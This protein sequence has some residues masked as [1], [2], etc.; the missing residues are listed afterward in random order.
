MKKIA[1]NSKKIKKNDIFICIHDEMLDRHKFI[2]EASKKASVLV[3]DNQDNSLYKNI[4]VPIIKVNDTNETLFQVVNTYYNYPFYKLKLIGVT[5]TDGKTTT[6]NM[7]YQ[8]LNNFYKC[9]YLGTNGFYFEGYFESTANTTPDILTITRL[10][11]IA[12]DNKVSYLVMEV[13]SEALLHN[14]CN[15]LKFERAILTNIT[16]E[17]LN[18]HKT[19]DN[20]VSNKQKLFKMIACD[21]K[22]I[23][24]ADENY[25][26][27]FEKTNDLESIYYGKDSN[28][29]YSFSNIKLSS[30]NTLFTLSHNNNSYLINSNYLGLYN[31]YNLVAAIAT[32][33]SL[34]IDL[35]EVLD[36]IKYLKPTLGRMEALDFNQNFTIL[37]DYAHTTNATLNVFNFLTKVK[38]KRIISVVGCAGGRYKDKRKEIGKIVSDYSDIAIFTMDDPRNEK[39][40]NIFKDML[41]NVDKDNIFLYKNRKKAIN[42]ALKLAKKDDIVII[43]GKGRDSYMAI[44]N[45]HKKYSDIKVI[46]RF[47]HKKNRVI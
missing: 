16:K 10:A 21:G 46:E 4:Y 17:H 40:T 35:S 44:K 2:E 14:R 20:Y 47:F 28:C 8:L 5:G 34:E 6:A 13:S 29:D 24:N 25:S 38:K 18:V 7:I 19:M 30:N 11:K 12:V 32:V 42:K 37:I 15:H 23:L 26:N 27:L 41:E 45:K 36:K 39:I 1:T 43:L 33:N 3:V 22:N 9:A 31:V